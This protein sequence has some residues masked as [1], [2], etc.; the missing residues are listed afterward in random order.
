LNWSEVSLPRRRRREERAG[1]LLLR[2]QRTRKDGWQLPQIGRQGGGAR[3]D[4]NSFLTFSGRRRR[5]DGSA[6]RDDRECRAPEADLR[7][8]TGAVAL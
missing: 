8:G 5:R 7:R 6:S 3:H 2:L 1:A 4:C